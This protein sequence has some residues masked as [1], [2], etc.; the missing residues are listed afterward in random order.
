MLTRSTGICNVELDVFLNLL[1]A[2]RSG[3]DYAEN[4]NEIVASLSTAVLSVEVPASF[5]QPLYDAFALL[6]YAIEKVGETWQRVTLQLRLRTGEMPAFPVNLIVNS[7]G[8]IV[9]EG[10]L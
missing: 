8:S 10:G 7:D 6:D 9:R 1:G 3:F 4:D 2:W 5:R